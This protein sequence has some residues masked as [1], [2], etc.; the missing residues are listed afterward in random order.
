ML[1]YMLNIYPFKEKLMN[2]NICNNCGGDYEYRNGRW[3]CHSCG[4][5]KPEEISN[6]EVTLLYTAFQKLRLAEFDEAEQEFDDIIEKYPEN[7]NAYWGRLMSKYGIKYEVDYDGRMIPTCYAESIESVLSD[8]DYLRALEYAD[9]DNRAYYKSQAEYMERVRRE[10]IEKAKKEKPY[11]VF[12]C[13]K[14][15]DLAKGIARTEDSYVAQ[16]IYAHLTELGYRVFYSHNSLR[17][18]VGEKYEPYIFHALS[19]AKVMLVYGS[20]PEYITSTWLKNEWTRYEKRMRL[21]E[22]KPNSLL[23]ACEGFSPGD[24]P[25]ALRARQCFDAGARSF[26]GDLDAVIYRIIHDKSKPVAPPAPKKVPDKPKPVRTPSAPKTDQK[27]AKS[28]KKW[29]IPLVSSIAVV[30]I[31]LSVI[32]IPMLAKGNKPVDPSDPTVCKHVPVTSGAIAPTCTEDGCTEGQICSLCGEVLQEA[33]VLSA[34]GHT[35][36]KSKICTDGEFCSVCNAKLSGA[37]GHK[38]TAAATCTRGRYCTVCGEELSS[39]AGHNVLTWINGEATRHGECGICNAMIYETVGTFD[40]EYSHGL[41]YTKNSDNTYTVFGIGTCRD[42]EIVI[43]PVYEGLPVKGIG[44]YAFSGRE[45]IVSVKIF[46]GLT[47]IG[48]YA[49]MKCTSLSEISIPDTVKDLGVGVFHSCGN[50]TEI[51]LPDDIGQVLKTETFEGC[52]NLKSF[53]VPASVTGTEFGTFAGCTNLESITVHENFM[54]FDAAFGGCESLSAIYFE[55]TV[56]Q[57]ENVSFFWDWV[58]PFTK[59]VCSDGE[60]TPS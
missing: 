15:S 6:E 16:E 17:D 56:A 27:S 52:F 42:T 20:K 7:P 4:S 12:I 36:D 26:Y 50:L 21:G 32:L 58:N 13:Y 10:W 11:D 1:K 30:V 49:F 57:W 29:M 31:A 44:A 54:G 33:T 55:G 51:T 5:F 2:T 40:G 3:V 43:P 46:P 59:V 39:P 47:E 14:D 28:G 53:T 23:V 37:K 25:A 22:K 38:L 19:T 41:K 9:E 34:L 48:D 18:K 8:R 35:S 24:L 45:E 60:V